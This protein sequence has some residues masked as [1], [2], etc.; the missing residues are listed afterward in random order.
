MSAQPVHEHDP[1]DP[2][3]ILQVLPARFHEQFLAEYA[4][5]AETARRVEGYRILHD[6]LRLWR[7]TAAA[8]AEP[9]FEDRLANVREAVRVGSM[10]GSVPV[11]EIVPDWADRLNRG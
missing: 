11:D 1:D 6:L 9:G 10:E 2:L 8:Y 7:L 3:E 4:T 5:A